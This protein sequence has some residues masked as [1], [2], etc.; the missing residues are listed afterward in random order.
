M[1]KPKIYVYDP[2]KVSLIWDGT[3]ITGYS[4]NSKIEVAPRGDIINP[5]TGVDG[6]HTY[7]IS[8]DKSGTVKITLMGGAAHV[9]TLNDDAQNKKRAQLAVRDANKDG[10][11][12][13]ACEDCIL[14]RTSTKKRAKNVEGEE[15]EFFVPLLDLKHDA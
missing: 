14:L 12:M 7:N 8:A 13:F 5:I 15:F 1:G 11:F 10:G 9:G 4:E 2:L 3:E 6:D